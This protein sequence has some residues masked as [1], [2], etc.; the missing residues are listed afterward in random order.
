MI[1]KHLSKK[2]FNKKLKMKEKRKMLAFSVRY[3]YQLI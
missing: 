1:G 3:I 2:K